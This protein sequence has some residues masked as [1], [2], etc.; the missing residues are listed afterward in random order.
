[1]M[2]TAMEL[3]PLLTEVLSE[4]KSRKVGLYTLN[5]VVTYSLKEPGLNP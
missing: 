1:M 5:P 4:R 3:P 2:G